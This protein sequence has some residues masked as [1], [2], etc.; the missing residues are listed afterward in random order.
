MAVALAYGVMI[1]TGFILVFFPVLILVLSDLRV[2]IG[3][4]FTGKKKSHEEMEPAIVFSKRK[5]D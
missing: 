5:I 4:L 2:F 1:G 3:W